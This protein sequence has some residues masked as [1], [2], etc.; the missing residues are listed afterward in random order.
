MEPSPFEIDLA[1]AQA[2]AAATPG[3]ALRSLA[4]HQG[5]ILEPLD[6]PATLHV[7]A[8]LVDPAP[9]QLPE[10]LSELES[11]AQHNE[12]YKIFSLPD[13]ARMSREGWPAGPFLRTPDYANRLYLIYAAQRQFASPGGPESASP[14]VV[15]KAT[16]LARLETLTE[17]IAAQFYPDEPA[18]SLA[19]QLLLSMAA[20][21]TPISLNSAW[22]QLTRSSA[23]W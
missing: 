10:F 14:L 11:R 17:K 16:A 13:C 18:H 9:D 12:R 1:M 23:G 4:N 21:P 20:P 15:R 22:L 19:R 3:L 5:W 6:Q 2:L 8:G 7:M